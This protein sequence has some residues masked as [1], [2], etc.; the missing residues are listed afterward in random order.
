MKI[1]ITARE[2]KLEAEVDPRFG[3]AAHF[4]IVET[5]DSN[6]E[7][8]E[9]PNVSSGGGA[10][11]QS[12][13]LIAGKGVTAVLTGSCGP[14]AYGVFAAAGV[15]VYVG[16]TGLVSQAV[17][18]FKSGELLPTD[19]PDVEA[20]TYDLKSGGR[21]MTG[22]RSK[23]SAQTRRGTGQGAGTCGV[24]VCPDCGTTVDHVRGVP[25]SE[26]TCPQCGSRMVRG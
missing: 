5:D 3:R 23:R 20:H 18:A 6:Y 22:G 8:I 17:E 13:Q 26:E 16:I 7:T 12:A 2:P 24:C 15:S 14:N 11:I 21:G 25:C 19:G 4:I 9:N 1:A 10:G